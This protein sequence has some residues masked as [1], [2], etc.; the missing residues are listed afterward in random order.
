MLETREMPK[1]ENIAGMECSIQIKVHVRTPH[2][3]VGTHS[4]KKLDALQQA[5]PGK[6]AVARGS[7]SSS[8]KASRVTDDGRTAYCSVNAKAALMRQIRDEGLPEHFSAAHQLRQ[9]HKAVKD[10]PFAPANGLRCELVGG[11][12]AGRRLQLAHPSQS[13]LAMVTC[14]C[15]CPSRRC[16]SCRLMY[17]P[18][19]VE[20]Y[21]PLKR[22]SS[23][24]L[25]APVVRPQ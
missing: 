8:S 18:R 21:M 5:C 25:L 6:R 16:S 2:T 22:R 19:S 24:W 11:V 23:L 3:P 9:R 15:S 13:S 10:L 4:R 1:E 17:S 14:S 7:A 20:P 12:D